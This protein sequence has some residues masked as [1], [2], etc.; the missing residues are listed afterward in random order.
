[1]FKMI[2]ML[3]SCRAAFTDF[4]QS[5]NI[6][7]GLRIEWGHASKSSSSSFLAISTSVNPSFGTT[8]TSSSNTATPSKSGVTYDVEVGSGGD[9]VFRPSWIEATTGDTINFKFLKLN[10]TL[11]ESSLEEPFTPVRGF[12]TGFHNFNPMNATNKITSFRLQ[13]TSPKWF[14][15][16][17]TTKS[18]HCNAGMVFSI[19][20]RN[21]MQRFLNNACGQK[22]NASY[23]FTSDTIKHTLGSA[24]TF[25]ASSGY[26]PSCGTA[27]A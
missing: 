5:G 4:N 12:N 8:I 9:L 17:Q 22:I 14:F 23:H 15:C 25:T 10:H 13:D 11:T 6:S 21:K 18:S 1:M 3:I 27:L 2:I 16:Q 19:N 20:P 7:L 26:L 24:Y